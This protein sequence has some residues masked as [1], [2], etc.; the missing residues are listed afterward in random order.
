MK[1][2]FVPQ[3]NPVGNEVLVLSL[4]INCSVLSPV[5]LLKKTVA[6]AFQNKYA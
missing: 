3:N 5:T 4:L 1:D 6:R 2:F